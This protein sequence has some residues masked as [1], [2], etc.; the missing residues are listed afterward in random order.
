MEEE[1]LKTNKQK[2][3]NP[4]K[5]RNLEKLKQMEQLRMISYL[6]TKGYCFLFF[7]TVSMLLLVFLQ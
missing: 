6:V 4:W 5:G 1:K 3:R 2:L 7:C